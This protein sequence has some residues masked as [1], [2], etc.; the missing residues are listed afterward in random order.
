MQRIQRQL[1]QPNFG[2]DPKQTRYYTEVP[3]SFPNPQETNS[4]PPA[5]TTGEEDA[6][7]H[8]LEKPLC[9]HAL[10]G[11]AVEK[12][13]IGCRTSIGDAPQLLQSPDLGSQS[14]TT[15]AEVEPNQIRPP[16]L[17]QTLSK[18]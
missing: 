16:I 4:S 13:A 6:P 12:K 2:K 11:V 1:N 17:H 14:T 9:T 5:V 7:H 15:V 18:S 8:E 10:N 3:G